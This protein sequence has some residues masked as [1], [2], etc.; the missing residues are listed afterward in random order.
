VGRDCCVGVF[1]WGG[2]RRPATNFGGNSAG[3]ES[4]GRSDRHAGSVCSAQGARDGHPRRGGQG[5]TATGQALIDAV[6]AKEREAASAETATAIKEAQAFEGWRA[7]WRTLTAWLAVAK[8]SA[9]ATLLTALKQVPTGRG[10]SPARARWHWR[11]TGEAERNALVVPPCRTGRGLHR[12][13][14]IPLGG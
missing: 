1:G 13:A 14:C 10:F 5:A 9:P 12:S 4:T 11:L 6:D 3:L 2:G 7:I 8:V